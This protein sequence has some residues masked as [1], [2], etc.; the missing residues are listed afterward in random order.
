M[1]DLLIVCYILNFS[2][3]LVFCV[4]VLVLLLIRLLCAGF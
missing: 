4:L 2:C 3:G 1:L